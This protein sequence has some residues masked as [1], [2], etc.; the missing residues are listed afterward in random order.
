MND[1]QPDYSVFKQWNDDTFDLEGK[2]QE[3]LFTD[4]DYDEIPDRMLAIWN[5][6]F[7]PEV[8]E[9]HS[10]FHEV[11]GAIAYAGWCAGISAVATGLGRPECEISSAAWAAL[12]QPDL[13][14]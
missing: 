11:F 14:K 5:V 12:D 10:A 4:G 3:A 2:L 8:A 6:M 9:R 13:G 7:A 1:K